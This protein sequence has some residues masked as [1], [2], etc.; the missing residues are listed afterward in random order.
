[1]GNQQVLGYEVMNEPIGVDDAVMAFNEKIARAIR[2]VDPKHLILFEPSATR[3]FTNGA[4]LSSKPFAVAGGV[5]SVHV[6]T[7]VFSSG[8][9]LADGTYPPQLEHSIAGARDEADS[10]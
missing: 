10:W 6:Y 7:A 2:S 8:S 4:P 9:A 3:N 5:Y 1:A